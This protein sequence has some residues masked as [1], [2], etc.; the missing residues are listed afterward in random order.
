MV[1]LDDLHWADEHTIAVQA[2]IVRRDELS[3][4]IIGTYRD[5]DLVRSHPLPKLLA[6][7]RR[8]HRVVRIPLQR[9]SDDEVEAMKHLLGEGLDAGAWGLSLGLEYGSERAA[10]FDEMSSLAEF[11]AKRNGILAV[12]TRNKEQQAVEAV[13]EAIEV[14]PDWLEGCPIEAEVFEVDRYQK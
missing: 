12:H 4:L 3:A 10:S 7:L 2:H 13:Q 14:T 1:V 11:S 6:D 5:T 9:L 8:E